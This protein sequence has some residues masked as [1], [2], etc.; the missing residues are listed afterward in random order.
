MNMKS[1]MSPLHSAHFLKIMT[2]I[3]KIWSWRV[4]LLAGLTHQSSWFVV[5]SIHLCVC[6]FAGLLNRYEWVLMNSFWRDLS[7]ILRKAAIYEMVVRNDY[8]RD[9][10]INVVPGLGGFHSQSQIMRVK[11]WWDETIIAFGCIMEKPSCLGRGLVLWLMAHL[12]ALDY[13]KLLNG[14]AL[15]GREN[16]IRIWCGLG[17]GD[18]F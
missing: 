3:F 6:L 18:F 1:Q 17:Q 10:D 2:W 13:T 16:A 11:L 14:F 4:L 5:V 7:W 9:H 12:I 8:Q 15:V